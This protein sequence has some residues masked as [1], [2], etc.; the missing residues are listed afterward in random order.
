ML[1][2]EITNLDGGKG[3]ADGKSQFGV[4]FHV[5]QAAAAEAAAI[6][7]AAAEAAAAEA[8]E[9]AAEAAAAAAEAAFCA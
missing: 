2:F 3:N 6:E 1:R 8:A 5:P 9:A 7:A 4:L